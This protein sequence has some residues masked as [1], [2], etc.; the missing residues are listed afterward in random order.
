MPRLS[1]TVSSKAPSGTVKEKSSVSSLPPSGPMTTVCS[2][3]G[4]I[5]FSV[6]SPEQFKY[7]NSEVNIAFPE[8]FIEK[9]KT[10]FVFNLF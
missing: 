10:L 3:L 1:V 2:I 4:T 7:L 8:T 6:V 5:K 9:L